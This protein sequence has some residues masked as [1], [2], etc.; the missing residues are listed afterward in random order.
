MEDKGFSLT[1]AEGGGGYVP[2]TEDDVQLT[3][4]HG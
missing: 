1:D 4:D 3:E 2:A